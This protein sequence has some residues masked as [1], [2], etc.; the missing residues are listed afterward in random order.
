MHVTIKQVEKAITGDYN[1]SQLGLSMMMLRLKRLYDKS[2]TA[3]VLKKSTD[4]INAFLK[5][6]E[7]IMSADYAVLSGL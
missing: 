2:P 6:Y 4:E 5:K 7:Q 3:E 1:F